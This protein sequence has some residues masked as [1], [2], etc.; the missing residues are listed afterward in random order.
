[1]ALGVEPGGVLLVHTSFK[2]VGLSGGPVELISAL[3]A[4]LGQSGTLV[5]PTMT[6]GASVY[7]PSSTPTLEMGITAETFW[8]RPGVVR[9]P[10]PGASFAAAGPLADVICAPHPLSPPHGL[11]SPVGRVFEH[12]GQI[13]LLGVGHDANTTLHLAESMAAVPYS[14]LHPCVVTVDGE[15]QTVMIA[16]TDHCCRGFNMTDDWL[17][18]SGQ[19]KEG[20]VGRA[21]ARLVPSRAV[22]EQSVLRLR[23]HPLLFLCSPDAFCAECDRARLSALN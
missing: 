12:G 19:Q 7:D 6:D 2:A 17:R 18:H 8:R 22:I 21:T 23:S 9:S 13:L 5:M 14:V 4:V 10:H 11:D 20:L 16:E 1:M 15:P 3:R